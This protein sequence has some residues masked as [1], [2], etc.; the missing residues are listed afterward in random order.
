[1]AGTLPRV[2]IRDIARY[3]GVSAAT[4]SR[5]L[6]D[7]GYVGKE[8]R[9]H[10]EEA[11]VELGY[12]P[13]ARARGLRGIPSKLVALII[14]D[15][16]NVYYTGV[17]Q[18]I[19]HHLAQ[20]GYIMLLGIT[21][22]SAGRYMDYLQFLWERRVDGVIYVPPATG[23]YSA[24]TR[25]LVRQ[26]IPF[27]EIN[28]QREA[29]LLDCVLADNLRGAYRG[30][31][32]LI[33]LGHERIALVVGSPETTTG[34]DRVQGF[35][36]AMMDAGLK[37][38]PQLLK[39]GDFSKDYGFEAME[40]LL[41]ISPRPTAVFATSNRLLM[42]TMTALAK[43]KIHVPDDISVVAFDD[44]EWLGFWQPPVTTVDIAV[45]EMGMLAVELL[46]R[47]IREGHPPDRPRTYSLS[48]M[49]VE[50]SSCRPVGTLPEPVSHSPRLELPAALSSI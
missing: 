7:S 31:E 29:D 24:H 30:A 37:I 26:G 21:G 12:R 36:L 49:L 4:V 33:G 39:I 10:V 22:E 17:S 40:E 3:A 27:V 18:A 47:W 50:R 48:T 14:P 25:R 23:D 44:S 43:H 20:R 35:K 19:E 5:V 6:N 28:R 11:I 8:T 1:V 38:D 34:A 9:R 13:D 41:A 2:T 42:G 45:E 15:I 32:H 46:M 16:L